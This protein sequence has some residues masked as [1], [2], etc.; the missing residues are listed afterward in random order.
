MLGDLLSRDRPA[1]RAFRRN[2]RVLLALDLGWDLDRVLRYAQEERGRRCSQSRL[3]CQRMK[4][5]VDRLEEECF[6]KIR[7][8]CGK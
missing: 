7:T 2:R 6:L 8:F 1:A 4:E 3:S 5:K